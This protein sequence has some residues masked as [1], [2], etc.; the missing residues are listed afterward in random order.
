MEISWRIL[1]LQST[2]LFQTVFTFSVTESSSTPLKLSSLTKSVNILGSA[3]SKKRN[4]RNLDSSVCVAAYALRSL[5]FGS[6]GDNSAGL[7]FNADMV[8]LRETREKARAKARA[9]AA[10]KLRPKNK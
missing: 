8:T 9:T 1:R 4:E 7:F 5:C 10:A 6:S 2:K 3:D